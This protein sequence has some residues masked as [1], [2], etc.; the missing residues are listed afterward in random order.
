MKRPQGWD[1]PLRVP[2]DTLR[3]LPR[4][5]PLV[6]TVSPQ[7]CF[8]GH[9]DAVLHELCITPDDEIVLALRRADAGPIDLTCHCYGLG[10]A[11]TG[12]RGCWSVFEDAVSP[13]ISDWRWNNDLSYDFTAAF[14][15]LE[16]TTS[17]V[18]ESFSLA[19][20]D[21]SFDALVY[22][23]SHSSSDMTAVLTLAEPATLENG[24]ALVS[25][26]G[27]IVA[28]GQLGLK[29]TLVVELEPNTGSLLQLRPL[30]IEIDARNPAQVLRSHAR[31]SADLSAQQIAELK[32]IAAMLA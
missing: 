2:F 27:S 12:Y 23:V 28:S 22:V 26:S 31:V 11:P 9:K 14:S 19:A 29:P 18:D 5:A 32:A 6:G 21:I 20:D 10:S 4:M 24:P 16:R 7:I 25:V 13:I 30:Q 8:T 17:L 15:E 3:H 1:S